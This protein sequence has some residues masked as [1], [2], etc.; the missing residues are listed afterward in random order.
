MKGPFFIFLL[1]LVPLVGACTSPVEPELCGNGEL[2]FGEDCDGL[3]VR[4][5]A[6]YTCALFGY[7]SPERAVCSPTCK[8]DPS[9]CVDSGICGD[10]WMTPGWEQ[11]D[12]KDNGGQTCE[13][14]GHHAGS[15]YCTED[16]RFDISRCIRCGDG[17][18][19]A[20]FGE[21]MESGAQHCLDA[22]YLGGVLYTD[23]CV[24][25][26]E[27]YCG[28][29]ALIEPAGSLSQPMVALGADKTIQLWG[30]ATAAFDG[31]SHSE[32]GCPRLDMLMDMST[33]PP[34]VIGY[35]HDPACEMEFFAQRSAGAMEEVRLQRA[36][37]GTIVQ[38]KDFGEAG[39][40]VFRRYLDTL[41]FEVV[42]PMGETVSSVP[43]AIT[44]T[45]NVPTL[46]R[47]SA[48][49]TG[50]SVVDAQ[51]LHIWE[52]DHVSGQLVERLFLRKIRNEGYEYTFN[53]R[54]D[55]RIAWV[56]ESQWLV[57]VNLDASAGNPGPGALNIQIVN[58]VP[59]VQ[60]FRPALS[61][62]TVYLEADPNS[63]EVSF[64]TTST[65]KGTH[66][67][68]TVFSLGGEELSNQQMDLSDGFI[69]EKLVTD[70]AGGYLVFGILPAAGN[71]GPLG[72][73]CPSAE[74]A[75][76]FWH[77]G[78]DLEI[79]ET[80]FIQTHAAAPI[81]VLNVIN[82]CTFGEEYNYIDGVLSY[83]AKRT[84]AWRDGTL[85]VA[86]TYDRSQ[87]FCSDRE[88]VA[89]E[90]DLPLHACGIYLL[91]FDV[92]RTTGVR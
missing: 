36:L 35:Q 7:N 64:L 90:D 15:L 77:L 42:D 38:A 23:N 3:Y 17:V 78:P 56:G 8:F 62:H 43:L 80:Q 51:G 71:G 49:R 11:C 70:G 37:D 81:P 2:N 72:R 87:A 79:L 40:F 5:S 65:Y 33:T 58:D 25:P 39:Y 86:G 29:Y 27:N 67:G 92:E 6:P 12:G 52:Y 30:R 31:F 13:S 45:D 69:P 22:G 19:Q 41:T 75:F 16:C 73:P 28:E 63:G 10:G 61:G 53:V 9:P 50:L 68:K 24:T 21:I 32:P 48:E 44:G 91:R 76:A 59:K 14:L 82:Y 4:A 20:E 54:F 1:M 60:V 55:H 89:R 83:V 84:Y 57:D 85:V 46:Q 74:Y 66:I 88:E 47:I 26:S 18:V 34:Q